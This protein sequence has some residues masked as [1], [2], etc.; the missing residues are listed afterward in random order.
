MTFYTDPEGATVW[1]RF[2]LVTNYIKTHKQPLKV[3]W[4]NLEATGIGWANLLAIPFFWIFIDFFV[5]LRYLSISQR[6]SII[7]KL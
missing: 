1:K 5:I 4:M 7:S 2:V 3:I 6:L